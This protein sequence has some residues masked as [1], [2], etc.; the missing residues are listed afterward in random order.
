VR[1]WRRILPYAAAGLAGLAMIALGPA[2]AANAERGG[3]DRPVRTGWR[4]DATATEV[5]DVAR[6]VGADR[7]WASGTTGDGVGVAL[8]DT[9]VTPVDGLRAV[10]HGPDLSVESQNPATRHLDTFG[11][12]THLAGIIAGRAAGFRG[13][14]P[15]ATLTSIKVGATGGAADV[16]QVIA[17]IDWVVAHR[18]DNPAG[19]IRV[20]NLAYGADGVQDYRIDPL[21]HA[22]ENAWRA[23]IVVVAAGGN[24]GAAAPRLANPAYDPYV[25]AVG[26]ADTMGT[27]R[28]QDD[29]LTDFS[30]RG[31]ATRR[32]D[33]VA[34]GRSIVSLR[35]PGGYL[36]ETYPGAR[37]GERLFKGSGTSQAA[38]VVSG[39]VA[40]LLERQPGLTPDEVKAALV[41]GANRLPFAE[42]AG[43]GAGELDVARAVADAARV[44]RSDV[45]QTWPTST[46]TG[47][48]EA[49][50]GTV[51]IALNGAPLVGE[52]DLFGPFDTAEWARASSAG[53][54][55][56]GGTWMGRTLTGEGWVSYGDGDSPWPGVS[57][58]GV[59]WSG[60]SWSGVSWSGVSWS[61]VSWSGVSWSGVSWS[62]VSWSG[63]S[64]SG[65]SWSGVSWSGVSWSGVSWSGVSW[66]GVSWSGVSWSGVSWSGVAWSGEVWA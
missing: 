25:L 56:D 63:V 34:P 57:W 9:G 37:V 2:E 21:T 61:G 31:D 13:I 42:G 48:L 11:H 14:A 65:V 15:G 24:G 50:R 64:W 28:A 47:S 49:S 16:S 36:D 33:L 35:N 4:F 1:L 38:A 60:V 58:S 3:G 52:Y 45:A 46:G 10:V 19:P 44:A 51:H 17:A 6:V 39:A 12:G 54:A 8:I 40:L 66:S 22:V 29:T 20:I 5:G 53:T 62:G 18:D 26:A 43:E 32:V 30:S 59:S 27:I 7:L 41:R 55:W 23:G